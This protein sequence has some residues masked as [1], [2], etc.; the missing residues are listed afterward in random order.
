[1][2]SLAREI[3]QTNNPTLPTLPSNTPV[4]ANGIS[5]QDDNVRIVG[6]SSGGVFATTVGAP[7][8]AEV[9][10]PISTPRFIGRPVIDRKDTKTANEIWVGYRVPNGQHLQPS[11]E[12]N[13]DQGCQSLN[14][15]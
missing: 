7:L 13:H 11:V 1:M 12:F 9:S 2:R 15:C 5:P 3:F 6:I 10:P 14:N 8:L 4:S